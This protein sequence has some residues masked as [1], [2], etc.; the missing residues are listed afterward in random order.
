MPE[1]GNPLQHVVEFFQKPGQCAGHPFGRKAVMQL[2]Q[3]L[4]MPPYQFFVEGTVF[5]PSAFCQPGTF[6]ELIRHPLVCRN[7]HY[8]RSML[9]GM[10]HNRGDAPDTL[11]I[12]DGRTAEF[13]EFPFCHGAIPGSASC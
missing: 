13:H 12:R 5:R 9:C 8:H 1:E 7:D 6:Q 4:M 2:A 10:K 11:A 3:N